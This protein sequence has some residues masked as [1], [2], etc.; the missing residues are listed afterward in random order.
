MRKNRFHILPMAIWISLLGGIWVYDTLSLHVFPGTDTGQWIMYSRYYIGE[1]VPFY[2][3]PLGVS[4][5][6][7]LLIG[8]S[9]F[10]TGNPLLSVK[11]IA[12]I[13]FSFLGL[14]TYLVVK[15]IYDDIAGIIA[16]YAVMLGQYLFVYLISFGGF[17]QLFSIVT[18]NIGLLCVVKYFKQPQKEIFLWGTA[19][20]GLIVAL[21]HYPSFPSFFLSVFMSY[22]L[23]TW[24]NKMNFV[25]V[26]KY[27]IK[28]LGLPFIFWLIYTI[29]FFKEETSYITNPAGYYRRGITEITFFFKDISNTPIVLLF[30]ALALIS[31]AFLSFWGLTRNRRLFLLLA[32]WFLSPISIMLGLNLLKV[33]TDYPRFIYLFI[34]PLI[35]SLSIFLSI[36]ATKN[37]F[38]EGKFIHSARSAFSIFRLTLVIFLLVVITVNSLF[39][40][41][42]FPNSLTYF[43]I[44]RDDDFKS[45]LTEISSYPDGK[46][47]LAPF[48]ESMWIEGLTGK[49]TLFFNEFR[50]LYRP[51]ELNRAIDAFLLTNGNLIAAENGYLFVRFYGSSL[52]DLSETVVSFH[53]KGEYSD[54]FV[55]DDKYLNLSLSQNGI[56]IILNFE[57]NFSG[58]Q[59][60]RLQ[61]SDQD[62]SIQCDY[63]SEAFSPPLHIIKTT[64]IDKDSAEIAISFWANIEVTR[65][66]FYYQ[67]LPFGKKDHVSNNTL[68]FND[69]YLSS[70]V[71]D[72]N[73]VQILRKEA[74]ENALRINLKFGGGNTTISTS[75]LNDSA[76]YMKSETNDSIGAGKLFKIVIKSKDNF[77]RLRE[78]LRAYK[79]LDLVT[80]NNVGHLLIDVRNRKAITLYNS[81]GFPIVYTNNEY[82]LFYA[83]P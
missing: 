73:N 53:S 29:L 13:I 20:A 37:N 35:W 24:S 23:F 18:L 34:E 50:Y 54:V 69:T 14:T 7:P 30:F 51:G 49:P 57:K 80:Q 83:K 16:L 82:V 43:S 67:D 32:L 44:K 74:N 3:V 39:S 79:L 10:L 55:I 8:I 27:N 78:G 47:V 42:L 62:I 70:I 17:P 52:R 65:Y 45:A 71:A 36:L 58:C 11:L 21:S 56:E 61:I 33:G 12:S 40:F 5:I 60:P 68:P 28:T 9:S 38:F 41:N 2:R 22:I 46:L 77:G 76:L 19:L 1:S 63:Y 6:I 26:I 81:L 72:Q 31:V 64:T 75:N 15:E 4:P 48:L 66:I 59:V 25:N